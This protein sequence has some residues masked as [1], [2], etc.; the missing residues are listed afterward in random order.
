MLERQSAMEKRESMSA[1]R[2]PEPTLVGKQHAIGTV[3]VS[4]GIGCLEKRVVDP[5]F[6]TLSRRD[7]EHPRFRNGRTFR[8]PGGDPGSFEAS[9]ERMVRE[10]HTVRMD[11][12]PTAGET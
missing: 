2:V 6:V 8:L 9:G 12:E 5:G 3:H 4:D 1:H 11:P 7:D 10:G